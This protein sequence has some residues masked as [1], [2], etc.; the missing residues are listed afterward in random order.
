M[1]M[2]HDICD[3]NFAQTQF[4]QFKPSSSNCHA[5]WGYSNANVCVCMAHTHLCACT[6][7]THVTS[8]AHVMCG[9]ADAPGTCTWHVQHLKNIVQISHGKTNRNT[10]LGL[11]LKPLGFKS[12]HKTASYVSHF[13]PCNGE[14]PLSLEQGRTP[15]F[16][17]IVLAY[18]P[19]F[20]LCHKVLRSVY[21]KITHKTSN[22]LMSLDVIF[23]AMEVACRFCRCS[24]VS[25][26][27]LSR[28][29]TFNN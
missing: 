28:C 4:G 14:C 22:E 16:A 9:R 10:F 6:H 13:V 20:W 5:M 26:A 23:A 21:G 29:F 1:I 25:G 12:S 2:M 3:S 11:K 17:T 19:N 7:H 8:H 27:P 15:G 24:N 18:V